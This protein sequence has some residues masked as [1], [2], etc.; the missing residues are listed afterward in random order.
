M[1]A[2]PAEY[3]VFDE[4]LHQM[5]QLLTFVTSPL[6]KIPIR[7][8]MSELSS[9][10]VGRLFGFSRALALSCPSDFFSG[11]EDVF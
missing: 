7:L 6:E 11:N 4:W 1:M 9:I 8:P 5:T 3:I 2:F 10:V